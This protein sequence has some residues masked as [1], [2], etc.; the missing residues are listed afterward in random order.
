M[1]R[2]RHPLQCRCEERSDAAVSWS[3]HNDLGL[4][5]RLR[6]DRNDTWR[7]PRSRGHGDERS[8]IESSPTRNCRVQP[9]EG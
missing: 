1:K 5:S 2:S 3:V 7:T 9:T 8:M 6:G 4:L